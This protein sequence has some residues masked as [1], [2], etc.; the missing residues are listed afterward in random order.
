MDRLLKPAIFDTDHNSPD[1]AKQWKHFYRTFQNFSNSVEDNNIR[2]QLL[3]N[4]ISAD[5]FQLIEE[6]QTYEQAITTL[7]RLY[8]KPPNTVYARH[9]LI[10]RRQ[11]EGESLDSFLQVL[12]SLSR[13]CYFEPVTADQHRDQYVRDSFITGIRSD[14]IRQ[15]LLENVELDLDAMFTQA[16][17]LEAA[18]RSSA[19]YQMPTYGI[20]AVN[21]NTDA[22]SS[23]PNL[24]QSQIASNQPTSAAV[25]P[26]RPPGNFTRCNCCGYTSHDPTD[27]SRCP[28]RNESCRKC[29]RVGHFAS[30]CRA[31]KKKP[32]VASA[33]IPT[34]GSVI[35]AAQPLA[36]KSKTSV[37]LKGE[38]FEGLVD[39]GSDLTFIHPRVVKAKALKVFPGGGSVSMANTSLLASSLGLC[40]ESLVVLG[41]NYNN[42]ELSVLP[43][44]CADIVLGKDFLKQH[45]SVSFEFGGSL[46]PLVLAGI[47]TLKIDPPAL[48]EHKHPNIKP[49]RAKR[50]RYSQDDTIFIKQEV[51]RLLAQGIIEPST[52]PWRAQCVITRN[53]NH[54][55]RLCIDYSETI[56]RYTYVDAYPLPLISDIINKIAQYN[57]HTT[58]DMETAYNQIKIRD[59]DKPLTAF[60]ANGA[61]YQFCRLPFGVSSGV[62]IFQREMDQFIKRNNLSGTYAYLDNITISGKTQ[63]EH[64]YNLE[65]FMEAARAANLKLNESK[66]EFSTRRLKLLGTVIENGTI[67]PDPDRI[68]PLI[69][70]P[71][72]QN[73]KELRRVMGL[74]AHYSQF[75]RC[76]SAKLHPLSQS[77]SFP[78]SSEALDA[79]NTLKK[80][81]KESIM[82]TIDVTAPF[83]LETDASDFAIA[84]VLNQSNRPVA[85]FSRS[86][87]PSEIKHS[88]VEKE[89]Q[90]I[91]EAVRYWRHYLTGAHFTLKTDQKSVSYM[92]DKQHQGKIKNEKI[93]R[94]RL[95]LSCYSYDIQH[96][97]GIENIA[98]D[99]LSRNICAGMSNSH[100]Y[101]L[102]ESLCHPGVTRMLHFVKVRNLP[103]SVEDVR[104]ITRDCQICAHNKPKFQ[105]SSNTHLIKATQPFE[106][107]SV[108]FKGPLPSNNKN[109]YL[110]DIIDEYSRFPFA[111]PCPD[112]KSSTV[113][114]CFN[115]LFSMFGMPSFIHTDQG[116]AFMSHEL[117]Q[118]LLSKNVATSRSTPYNPQCNGQ[119]EKLNDTLWRS[120]TMA[121]QSRGLPQSNWQDVLPDALHS[122][123]SLLCT[124]TNTTPHERLF[125][126]QR[127][128]TSGTSVPTWLTEKDTALLKR[129]VR[130]SKQEPLCDEVQ[131]LNVNPNYAHIRTADGQ[132]KTVSLSK[133]SQP[134]EPL[135]NHAIDSP[136]P[137]NNSRVIESRESDPQ[138]LIIPEVEQPIVQPVSQQPVHSKTEL[139]SKPVPVMGGHGKGWCNLDTNNILHGSRRSQNQ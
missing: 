111:F 15:R 57:I 131:I 70:L 14:Q 32:S 3:I 27:R 11:K 110:L 100:L 29:L 128:S 113:I 21:E 65:K 71:P 9:L 69:D 16:R 67:S 130:V 10:T 17:S 38:E 79:F 134:G 37:I 85:F 80:D 87:Q 24:D 4:H 64:D 13:D 116:S 8:I 101:S 105:K 74:F 91:V 129:N 119:V 28:A 45:E 84:A 48:F 72:P 60:E 102:H 83:T 47:G 40:K 123:R 135:L 125:L 22:A 90:A 118:Y 93:S 59:E 54:K 30:V 136:D 77:T 109:I 108:D 99:A 103:F 68:K 5:I 121:L 66:C 53:E 19:S 33:F 31:G 50:R 58:V 137:S 126:F 18:Q 46:P 61:L 120:I 63:Q 104:Q 96:K 75:I 122:I 49:I 89:A 55:K 20:N 94:W 106:R 139:V 7:K 76:F 26:R 41:Q 115:Q 23:L 127:K 73:I 82:S 107:L 6:C 36:D 44:L 112:T 86:L 42:M 117:K 39:T 34:L 114:S 2:L 78:L 98:A 132:E 51:E 43:D 81:I 52:S 12:K 138:G 97:P 1:A 92:F 95:E 133:L 88:S 25:T 62:A 35:A 56:N 124:A